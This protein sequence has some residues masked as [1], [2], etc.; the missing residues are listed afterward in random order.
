MG[1][2]GYKNNSEHTN[3]KHVHTSENQSKLT[4]DNRVPYIKIIN[5]LTL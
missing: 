2:R 1:G 5:N 3:I 4:Y